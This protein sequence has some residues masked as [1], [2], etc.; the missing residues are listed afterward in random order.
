MPTCG[1]RA[2]RGTDGFAAPEATMRDNKPCTLSRATDVYSVGAMLG[3]LLTGDFELPPGTLV[4]ARRP[5]PLRALRR[6]A[7]GASSRPACASGRVQ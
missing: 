2:R 1:G 5:S 7:R 4:R 6:R 3:T